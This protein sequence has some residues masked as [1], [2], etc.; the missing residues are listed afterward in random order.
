MLTLDSQTS[1]PSTRQIS[2][3]CYLYRTDMVSN[4]DDSST[5]LFGA[6]VGGDIFDSDAEDTE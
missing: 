1:P 3:L 5:N 6:N 4:G 2:A